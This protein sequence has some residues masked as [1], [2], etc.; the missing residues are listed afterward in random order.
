MPPSL[1]ELEMDLLQSARLLA[2]RLERLSADSY[3]AHQAS[4]LRGA[5]LRSLDALEHQAALPHPERAELERILPVMEQLIERGYYIL[6]HAARLIRTP[7]T[8]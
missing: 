4:G 8:Y 5:L 7:D 2:A 3:W 6:R 1:S